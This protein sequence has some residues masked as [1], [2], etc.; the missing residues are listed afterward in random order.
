MA[1]SERYGGKPFVWGGKTYLLA[2][3]GLGHMER[4]IEMT[5]KIASGALTPEQSKE[6]MIKIINRSLMRNYPDLTPEYI[7]EEILDLTNMKELY[8]LVL[9]ASGLKPA[10]KALAESPVPSAT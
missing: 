3:I 1:D 10:G 6:E 5:N 7:R 8:Q 2:P 9:D 4:M